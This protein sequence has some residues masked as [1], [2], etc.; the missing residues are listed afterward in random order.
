MARQ[1]ARDPGQAPGAPVH[2]LALLYEGWQGRWDA[3]VE[4]CPLRN[5]LVGVLGARAAH[6][7]S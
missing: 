7:I 3:V 5:S 6:G 4:K 1:L 2:L